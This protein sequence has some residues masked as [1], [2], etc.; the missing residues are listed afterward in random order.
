[1]AWEPD[2]ATPQQLA[3]YIRIGDDV[4]DAQLQLAVTSS[5]RAIDRNTCRQFGLATAAEAR[6]YTAYWSKSRWAWLVPIDDLMTIV[7]LVIAVDTAGDGTYATTLSTSDY[8]LRPRNAAPK[9]RPWTEIMVNPRTSVR[10]KGTD[11]EFQVTLR[12]GWTTV[13]ATVE[14]ACLLQ[15][16][17]FLARRDAPFGVA[18]SPD[19]GSELRLLAKVDPDVAVILDPYR[20][21]VW[22]R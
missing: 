19:A 8:V 5:S 12:P 16:S 11:G 7:G 3:D 2:Y 4:D 18:G 17:R 9:N 21:K 22:A 6:Q 20:R 1:M 10:P 13:P 15:G 14:Q